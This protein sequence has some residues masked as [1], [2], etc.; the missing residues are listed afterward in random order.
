VVDTGG[1]PPPPITF[2]QANTIKPTAAITPLPFNSPVAVHSAIV[3]CLNFPASSGAKL[4]GISDTLNNNYSVVVGP[5]VGNSAVHYVAVALDSKAG[6]DTIN[7]AATVAPNGGSDLLAL[8]YSGL[9]LSGAFDVT[10]SNS[11]TTVAMASGTATTTFAHELIIGYGEASAV[12]AGA[13]YTGRATISGNLVE[14][15][16]VSSAGSYEATATTTTTAG[17]QMIMATFKGR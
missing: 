1:P 15:M 6:P 13:G 8:E 14:D 4:A 11:G 2:V 10:A 16:I 17:W 5:V 12:A 7:V 3:I 9:S